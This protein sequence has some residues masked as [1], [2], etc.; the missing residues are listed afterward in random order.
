MDVVQTNTY[1]KD[2]RLEDDYFLLPA[3]TAANR[4][5]LSGIF[6]RQRTESFG[7]FYND[8]CILSLLRQQ[9]MITLRTLFFLLIRLVSLY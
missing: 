5:L 4:E 1:V 8:F 7:R 3:Q 9:L 6:V 2:R